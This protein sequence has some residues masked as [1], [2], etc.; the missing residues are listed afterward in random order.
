MNERPANSVDPLRDRLERAA[1]DLVYSSESDYP[2]EF[3][4]V[5]N[6]HDEGAMLPATALA[7]L[8]AGRVEGDRIEERSLDQFFKRH[9]ETSDPYD[10]RAQAVRPRY[11]AL[12]A[13]LRESLDGVRVIRVTRADDRAVVRCF[14]VGRDRQGRIAGLATS[15]IE[16]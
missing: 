13:I 8:V 11:E 9:I 4:A 10:E 7:E 2:F 5:D 6:P 15:A 3:F 16:T 12:K 14:V 1:A